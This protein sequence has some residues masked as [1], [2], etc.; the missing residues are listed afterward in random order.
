MQPTGTRWEAHTQTP[1]PVIGSSVNC[2]AEILIKD[3]NVF[4]HY[5]K[6]GT[7]A[8]QL[9]DTMVPSNS[10]HNSVIYTSP[11]VECD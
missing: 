4:K 7:D 9:L 1:L 3:N 5:L 10:G 8:A 6:A 2:R 11:E